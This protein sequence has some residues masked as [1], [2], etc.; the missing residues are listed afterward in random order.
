MAG[1]AETPSWALPFPP[2]GLLAQRGTESR[3]AGSR[4][5]FS[6]LVLHLQIANDE[7]D[8]SCLPPFKQKVLWIGTKSVLEDGGGGGS[9]AY[10]HFLVVWFFFSY[11]FFSM[12]LYTC[13]FNLGV[14]GMS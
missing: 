6:P 12:P 8:L 13:S 1:G 4:A 5:E 14:S 3:T 10:L 9:W 11:C 2:R 7:G